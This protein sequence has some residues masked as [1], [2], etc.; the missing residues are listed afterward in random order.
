MRNGCK[1]PSLKSVSMEVH[2]I[3]NTY[4]LL[5]FPLYSGN[6]YPR[7]GHSISFE[8]L[9]LS[10]TAIYTKTDCFQRAVISSTHLRSFPSTQYT[11][12]KHHRASDIWLFSNTMSFGIINP[13]WN[14]V[15]YHVD[16]SQTHWGKW[17]NLAVEFLSPNLSLNTLCKS[18][19]LRVFTLYYHKRHHHKGRL[20]L[21]FCIIGLFLSHWSQHILALITRQLDVNTVSFEIVTPS[22]TTISADIYPSIMLLMGFAALYKHC[23]SFLCTVVLDVMKCSAKI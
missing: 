19:W 2:H 18:T 23:R 20:V 4:S 22:Q 14:A 8:I 13:S 5:V 7:I 15:R 17:R 21:L 3:T 11:G 12:P 6:R 10:W 1:R 16:E 9:N